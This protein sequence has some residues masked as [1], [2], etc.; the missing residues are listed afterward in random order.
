MTRQYHHKR[1]YA[2]VRTRTELHKFWPFVRS[3]HASR[4]VCTVPELPK[5]SHRPDLRCPAGTAM[6]GL[7]LD[8]AVTILVVPPGMETFRAGNT[9]PAKHESRGGEVS[10]F[11]D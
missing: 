2:I 3:S 6:M 10:T 9:D 8:S 7:G 5:S 11:V 4:G 1:Y